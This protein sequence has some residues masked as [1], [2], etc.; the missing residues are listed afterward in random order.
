[1]Q[2]EIFYFKNGLE[3][4]KDLAKKSKLESHNSS[5]SNVAKVVCD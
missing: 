4:A 3:Q 1:M 5:R 2:R